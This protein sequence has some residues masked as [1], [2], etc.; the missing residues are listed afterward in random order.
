MKPVAHETE[1]KSSI[2]VCV[3][4]LHKSVGVHIELHLTDSMK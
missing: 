2:E 1:D 4:Y 3:H